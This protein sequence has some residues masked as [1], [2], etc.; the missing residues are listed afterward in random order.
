MGRETSTGV[1]PVPLPLVPTVDCDF[2]SLLFLL[3]FPFFPLGCNLLS[4]MVDPLLP[5]DLFL[6]SAFLDFVIAE[7]AEN[8]MKTVKVG[9]TSTH[10]ITISRSRAEKEAPADCTINTMACITRIQEHTNMIMRSLDKA[11]CFS[12]SAPAPWASVDLSFK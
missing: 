1:E 6:K 10:I 5:S 3:F 2:P 11:F 9:G 4:T 8:M 7:L 12:L